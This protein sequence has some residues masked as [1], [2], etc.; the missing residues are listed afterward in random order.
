MIILNF[1]NLLSRRGLTGWSVA[2]IAGQLEADAARAT[3]AAI[4]DGVDVVFQG[5]LLGDQGAGG[6]VLLG[7]PDFLVR[8]GLENH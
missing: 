4:R 8:A 2:E 5:V 6:T 7:R 1:L 3:L